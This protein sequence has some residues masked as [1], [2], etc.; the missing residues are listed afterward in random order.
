[1]RQILRAGSGCLGCLTHKDW[2]VRKS[3]AETLLALARMLG[4]G[5]EA[6]AGAERKRVARC[7]VYLRDVRHDRVKPAREALSAAVAA[8]EDLAAWLEMHPV[9]Q[10]TAPLAECT[11]QDANSFV[12]PSSCLMKFWTRI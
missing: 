7:L 1:M 8:Y 2:A 6:G 3:A 10:R 12:S 9:R 11:H 4:P 5:V